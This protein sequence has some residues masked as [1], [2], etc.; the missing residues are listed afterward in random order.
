MG[1][2]LATWNPQTGT[3]EYRDT[4]ASG[5]D[6][7]FTPSDPGLRVDPHPHDVPHPGRYEPLSPELFSDDVRGASD[8]ARMAHGNGSPHVFLVMD[9][10]TCERVGT[11]YGRH[12]ERPTD[13]TCS[14]CRQR[15]AE[16]PAPSPLSGLSDTGGVRG[17]GSE[18]AETDGNGGS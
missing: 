9:C 18:R 3:H 16:T 13:P 15:T 2:T 10:P 14:S 5:D 7:D 4:E 12:D 1:Y 6:R 17:S 8:R 11:Y